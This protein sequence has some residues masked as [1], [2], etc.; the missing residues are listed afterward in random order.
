MQDSNVKK[1]SVTLAP[2]VGLAYGN[3]WRQLWKYF[4]EL[5]LIGIIGF[6]IGIPAGMGGLSEGAT[7]SLVCLPEGIA[8]GLS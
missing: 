2:G 4:L 5:F 3:G 8:G 1:N 6:V 7:V